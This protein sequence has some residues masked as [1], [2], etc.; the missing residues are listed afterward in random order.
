MDIKSEIK[1]IA[2]FRDPVEEKCEIAVFMRLHVLG[3]YLV[4]DKTIVLC[5]DKRSLRRSLA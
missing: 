2:L 1:N 3:L 5:R 4:S